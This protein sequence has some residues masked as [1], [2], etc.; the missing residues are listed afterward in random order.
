MT[1]SFT[2]DEFAHVWRE[3]GSQEYPYPLRIVE[4]TRTAAEAT[5]LRAAIEQRLPRGADPE[6]SAA[7]RLAAAP[8]ARLVAIGGG[9]SENGRIRLLGTIAANRATLIVQQPVFSPGLGG[10]VRIS[11]HRADE[12]AAAAIA[13]LPPVGRGRSPRR[14]VAEPAPP[15]AAAVAAGSAPDRSAAQVRRVLSAPRTGEGHIRIDTGLHEPRPDTPQYLSW[16]DIARDGRYL[17]RT[18]GTIR[19]APVSGDDVAAYLQRLLT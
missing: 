2:P 8:A 1:W 10:I 16:V 19:I 9:E 13:V 17:I 18:D 5:R 14:S 11:T 12:L 6:L 3:T 4:P 7:L 15:G